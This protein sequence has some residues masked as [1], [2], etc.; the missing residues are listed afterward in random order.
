MNISVI[1]FTQNGIRLSEKLADIRKDVILYTK[2][3]AG[4][5]YETAHSVTYARQSVKEWAQEEM[6]KGNALLFIGACG[7]AV[8]AIAP[9][10]SDKLYDSPV[11]VADETGKYVIPILS[12]HIGGANRI[13]VELADVLGAQPVI[14]T[15]TDINHKFAVDLFAKK[16]NFMISNKD[17]IAKV[18]AKALTG[19]DITIS[20][21]TGHIDENCRRHAGVNIIPYPPDR[22]V[23]V[24]VTGEDTKS[25]AALLLRP[26]EY[27]VGIGCKKGKE[28]EKI[29]EFIKRCEDEAGILEEQLFALASVDLKKDEQGLL[30]WSRKH[31]IPFL[32][33]TAQQLR[34]VEGEFEPSPFVLE[35]TG[36]DNVCERAAMKACEPFGRL[37]YGKHA[38]DGM[39]IAIAKRKWSVTFDEE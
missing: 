22:Y 33:Y 18:S 9:Y 31:H 11:I 36:V 14:T 16:N 35:K 29:E 6:K 38:Q 15:A 5:K 19:Q 37:I 39:T 13:A 4:E 23:D 2:C 7:I 8:R 28:T 12:G 1:S 27:A 10:V 30:T 21:E 32:T 25:D 26:K 24:I 34:S 17:G 3:S 20:V